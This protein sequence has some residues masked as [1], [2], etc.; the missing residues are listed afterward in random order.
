MAADISK[1]TLMLMLERMWRIRHFELKVIEVYGLGEFVGAAHPYI[2]EE[3]VAV[4][5]CVAMRDTDYIA[6][7]HRSH[8]H[9]IAKGA[10]LNKAMAEIYG[11]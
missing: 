1:D 6:G 4:G 8:G 5:A 3:A 9:P 10:D 11:R 7:H 2:G